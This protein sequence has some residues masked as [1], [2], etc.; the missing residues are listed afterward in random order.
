LSILPIAAAN[1]FLDLA[2]L[3][4]GA[5]IGSFVQRQ[6]EQRKQEGMQATGAPPRPSLP[7]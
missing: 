1:S 6:V 5:F 3:T 7:A 2:K 4:L